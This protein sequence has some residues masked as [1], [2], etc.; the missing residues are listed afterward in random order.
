MTEITKL[1]NFGILLLKCMAKWKRL[2]LVMLKLK[3]ISNSVY[4]DIVHRFLSLQKQLL[5]SRFA[6]LMP[7]L[8]YYR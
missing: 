3:I 6:H 8:S 1:P 2:A 5:L 7:L 4:N